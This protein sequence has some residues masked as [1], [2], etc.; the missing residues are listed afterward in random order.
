MEDTGE[1]RLGAELRC[2]GGG[3]SWEAICEPSLGVSLGVL[4]GVLLGFFNRA[5]LN[6]SVEEKNCTEAGCILDE[7][8]PPR[9]VEGLASFTLPSEY[10][11]CFVYPSGL[12]LYL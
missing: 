2:E 11:G 9:R 4:S 3:A 12:A 8:P 10:C 6:Q 5:F 1:L 7:A